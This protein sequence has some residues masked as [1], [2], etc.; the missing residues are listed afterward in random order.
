MKID[1][2]SNKNNGAVVIN[3]N[4]VSDKDRIKSALADNLNKEVYDITEPKV[5]TPKILLAHINAEYSET[6]IINK[7]KAQNSYLNDASLKCVKIFKSR[8]SG[9]GVKET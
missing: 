2:V 1:R 4:S 8:R 7:I 9:I 5:N 6:E 3:A